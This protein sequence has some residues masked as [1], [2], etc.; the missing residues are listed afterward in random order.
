MRAMASLLARGADGARRGLV[1][2]ARG[3]EARGQNAAI[4]RIPD[5]VRERVDF[6]REVAEAHVPKEDLHGVASRLLA[7]GGESREAAEYAGDAGLERAPRE[8]T[9]R[10]VDH[11]RREVVART[12]NTFEMAKK[13]QGAAAESRA[14]ELVGFRRPRDLPAPLPEIHERRGHGCLLYTSPSP[15]DRTRY[16][17]PSS[18]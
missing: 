7:R 2:P 3:R 13:V 14:S 17:M 4:E 12:V 11:P 16:R 9:V 5:D 10:L 15:R 6:F 18:A 1:A 8:R